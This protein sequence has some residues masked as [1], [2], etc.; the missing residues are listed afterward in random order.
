[1]FVELLKEHYGISDATLKPIENGVM[2]RNFIVTT[3]ERSFV[4][5]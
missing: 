1:M 5:K 4:L 3:P 2:N